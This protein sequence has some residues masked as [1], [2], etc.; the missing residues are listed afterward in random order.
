MTADLIARV[1][2]L[3]HDEI[4]A[5]RSSA[6]VV[7]ALELAEAMEHQ[8]AAVERYLANCDAIMGTLSPM[9]KSLNDLSA[10]QVEGG[11]AVEITVAEYAD[12]PCYKDHP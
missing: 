10:R 2:G 1:R 7:A 12:V 11:E 6:L 4:N 5:G 8:T 9:P 3:C